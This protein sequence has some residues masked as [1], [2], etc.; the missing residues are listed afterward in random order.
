M[1]HA[2][3][4]IPDE[5]RRK[6]AARGAEGVA[7]LAGLGKLV[8]DLEREWDLSF[9]RVLSGGTEAFV[10]EVGTA[11]GGNAVVK[12]VPPWVDPSGSELRILL[13]ANG[14][15][16]VQVLG[17]DSARGVM[18]LE[19]LGPLLHQLGLSIETQLEI[20]CATLQEA[21][22]PLPKGAQFMSGAEK[23][24]DLAAFIETTW[25][26]LGEP[27][28]RHAIDLA[29]SFAELR[30][31][32]FDPDTA[33]LAHGDA[34]AWNTLLVPGGGPRRFKFIDPDGLFIERAYDLAV[35]M[36]EWAAEL[37][38]G[39]PLTLGRRRCN[40]LSQLTGVDPEPIWQWGY[41]ERVSSG[42]LLKHLR[43]DQPAHEFL[44]VA[45]AWSKNDLK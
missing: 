4:D 16:Y 40:Y 6:A 2:V 14:R 31:K 11:N 24:S 44:T 29:L 28:S 26:E 9:M 27:C 38:A 17:H 39:D 37:L 3:L 20:I 25:R 41:I 21:W 7:W 23:A 45:E 22:M 15:G 32:A 10:A 18:L 30:R 34:H 13:A 43:M 36:R 33:V 19:R 1:K 35:A 42:L 12:I 5:V 8:A